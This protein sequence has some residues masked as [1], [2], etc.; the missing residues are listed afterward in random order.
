V[1]YEGLEGE[2]MSADNYVLIKYFK[3][4]YYWGMGFASEKIKT[5]RK[6]Y[7]HGPFET[8][9]QASINA[10]NYCGIIEYGICYDDNCLKTN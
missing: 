9:Q 5:N 2:E 1:S 8:P 6:F 7:K 4:G 3:G 10:V